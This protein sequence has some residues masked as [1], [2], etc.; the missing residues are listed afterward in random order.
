MTRKVFIIALAV[1]LSL[2]GLAFAEELK[3]IKLA[4][5]PYSLMIPASFVNGEVKD[6][7]RSEGL[8]AYYKSDATTLDFDVYQISGKGTLAEFAAEDAK[9]FNGKDIITDSE[10]NGV[11]VA[12]YRSRQE[13][14]GTEYDV[15]SYVF[16]GEDGKYIRLTFWLDGENA[17]AGTKAIINSLSK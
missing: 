2:A 1:L 16:G 13:D 6:T 12:S 7:E 3:S 9:A 15:I 14:E 5:S 8:T 10:I 17:E 4:D 11:K